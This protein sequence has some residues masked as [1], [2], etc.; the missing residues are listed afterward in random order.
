M[1]VYGHDRSHYMVSNNKGAL[2]TASPALISR[3]INLVGGLTYLLTPEGLGLE[4]VVLQR[5]PDV[6]LFPL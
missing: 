2:Q 6:H 5:I 3:T 4:D 1:D